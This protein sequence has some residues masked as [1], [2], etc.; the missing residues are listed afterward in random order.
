MK[1]YYF[2]VFIYLKLSHAALHFEMVL[3]FSAESKLLQADSIEVV[4]FD[5]VF[6]TANI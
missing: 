6:A 2:Y 4:Q 3:F 5:R 1:K